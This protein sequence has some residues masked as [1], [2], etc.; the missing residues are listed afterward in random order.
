MKQTLR[1][2]LLRVRGTFKGGGAEVEDELRFHLQ[3]A[4][5]E[6]LRRGESPREA[7]LRAGGLAQASESVRDQIA[8]RWLRDFFRDTRHGARLLAKGP[9]FA[10]V[11]IGSLALGI[12]GITAMFSAV[13]AVLIRPLPY[14]DADR[15]VMIWLDM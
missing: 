1:E 15:L 9:L 7:R 14:A 13:D 3:M 8:I 11:A 6:A 5:Q 12:G 2:W 4:E 10:S